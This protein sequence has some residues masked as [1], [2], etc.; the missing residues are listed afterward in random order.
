MTG[1]GVREYARAKVRAVFFWTLVYNTFIAS[2]CEDVE[3]KPF[4]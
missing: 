4:Y 2:I 3:M 1:G